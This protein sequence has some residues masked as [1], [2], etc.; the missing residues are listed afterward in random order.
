[1][2]N[3][4]SHTPDPEEPLLIADQVEAYLMGINRKSESDAELDTINSLGI[5]SYRA[6]I[7][8]VLQRS[9]IIPPGEDY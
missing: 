3:E 1:M 4:S 9:G 2:S 8:G 7:K 5:D 6:W